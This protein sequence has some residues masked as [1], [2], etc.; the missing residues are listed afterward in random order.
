MAVLLTTDTNIQVMVVK[1]VNTELDQQI[2][3]C[4]IEYWRARLAVIEHEISQL[5]KRI[6]PYE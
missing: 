5:L 4:E 1:L 2:A 3:Q 6:E